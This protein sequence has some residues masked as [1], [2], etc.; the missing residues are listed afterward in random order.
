MQDKNST[1]LFSICVFFLFCIFL[2]NSL[3]IA[4]PLKNSWV[5]ACIYS[6][7]LVPSRSSSWIYCR[8]KKK[9]SRSSSESS[10]L[11]FSARTRMHVDR[12]DSSFCQYS[13]SNK[14]PM[15]TKFVC[16]CK[17]IY[18]YIHVICE[19]ERER[20]DDSCMHVVFLTKGLRIYMELIFQTKL[21]T[22]W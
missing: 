14:D 2:F 9:K 12:L 16:M 7:F 21:D 6:F 18:I 13:N 19:R 3:Y 15:Q 8:P 1:F 4:P 22:L 10:F 17:Y 20:G 5:A 11:S